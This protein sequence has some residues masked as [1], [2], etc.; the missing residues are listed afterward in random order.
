MLIFFFFLFYRLV[1]RVEKNLSDLTEFL[2]AKSELENW[3]QRAHGTVKDCVGVGD[4][5]WVKDKIDTINLVTNRITEGN[6]NFIM[7]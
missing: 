6:L 2:K 1:S 7:F 4:R 5:T 3:L